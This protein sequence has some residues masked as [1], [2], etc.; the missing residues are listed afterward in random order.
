MMPRCLGI[1]TDHHRWTY[2]LEDTL[3]IITS[4]LTVNMYIL[5]ISA[6]RTSRA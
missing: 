2:V 3:E 1:S 6:L 4:N 5:L